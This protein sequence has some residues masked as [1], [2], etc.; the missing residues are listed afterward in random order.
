MPKNYLCAIEEI[1]AQTATGRFGSV[2]AADYTLRSGCFR[3]HSSRWKVEIP[4][5]PDF[6][7]CFHREQPF[8]GA[9]RAAGVGQKWPLSYRSERSDQRILATD[10]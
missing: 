6:S 2:P 8:T 1:D 7:V 10:G 3:V 4:D 9:Y 5:S